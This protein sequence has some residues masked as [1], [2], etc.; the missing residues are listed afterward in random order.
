MLDST[1]NLIINPFSGR[2]SNG[3]RF[4][5]S[6][7]PEKLYLGLGIPGFLINVAWELLRML[8]KNTL[9][10]PLQQ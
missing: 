1:M 4:A 6:T 7:S 3:R 8:F 5:C 9:P 2:I 10:G